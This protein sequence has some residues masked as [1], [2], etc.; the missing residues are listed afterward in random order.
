MREN[1]NV[2]V[3]IALKKALLPLLTSTGEYPPYKAVLTNAQIRH[4]TLG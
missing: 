1:K 4:Y 3:I 2:S